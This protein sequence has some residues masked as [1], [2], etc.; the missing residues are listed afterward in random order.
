MSNLYKNETIQ[1][2]IILSAG[3]GKRLGNLTKEIPK[4]MVSINNAPILEHNIKMCKAFGISKIYINTH[5]LSKKITDYFNDGS[6][7][8]LNI[9]YNN[10]KDLLGTA[11]ALEPFK[12]LIEQEPFLVIYGDNY[13]Y[14]NDLN[15]I[16]QFHLRKKS[17][18]TIQVH[19]KDDCSESGRIICDKNNVLTD[20]FEKE[21]RAAPIAGYVNSGIYIINDIKM[22]EQYICKG[23]DFAFDVIPQVIKKNSIYIF[24]TDEKI[25]SID[26]IELLNNAIKELE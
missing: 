10:E 16:F 8:D 13:Y 12:D 15:K 9:F 11:G 1:K 4:P 6:K 24:K 21:S 22:I 23:A 17:K 3:K 25:Y 19:W 2:A 18:F 14:K 26:S 20:I 7:F 5:H